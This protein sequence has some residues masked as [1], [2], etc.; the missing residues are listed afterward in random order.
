MSRQQQQQ[1]TGSTVA[2]DAENDDANVFFS[3]A[4]ASVTERQLR[5]LFETAGHIVGIRLKRHENKPTAFGFVDFADPKSARAAVKRLNGHL[6]SPSSVLGD[7]GTGV[8]NGEFKLRVVLSSDRLKQRNT[9]TSSSVADAS[10]LAAATAGVDHTGSMTLGPPMQFPPSFKDP[11][12]NAL[13][14][15]SIADAYEAVEQL[16]VLA[17]EKPHETRVL[18]EMN[19][20]LKVAAVM[21]LQHADRLPFRLPKEALE[22]ADGSDKPSFADLVQRQASAAT[23]GTAAT[24]FST[25]AASGA[26]GGEAG[27]ASLFAP[28]PLGAT[29]GLMAKPLPTTTMTPAQ[30]EA[31]VQGLTEAQLEKLVG[32]SPQDLEKVPEP[33]R[34]QLR[35]LQQDLRAVLDSI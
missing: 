17:L 24:Y 8:I 6:F 13:R 30:L 35:T 5:V 4:P 3:N 26:T 23:S 31:K 15:V 34:S 27:S 25:T 2:E 19:P 20:A 16:R 21:I 33:S 18:L 1:H 12:S 14:K 32:M 29:S 7:S 11:I 28:R 9:G 10:A 22:A